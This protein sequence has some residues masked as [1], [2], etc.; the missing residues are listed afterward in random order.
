M[1]DSE[2]VQKAIREYKLRRLISLGFFVAFLVAVG[3]LRFGVDGT[4][5]AVL[6]MASLALTVVVGMRLWQ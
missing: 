5:A 2:R 1:Q 3:T 6:S 4:F